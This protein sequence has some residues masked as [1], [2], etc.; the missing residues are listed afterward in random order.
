MNKILAISV[1]LGVTVMMVGSIMPTADAGMPLKYNKCDYIAQDCNVFNVGQDGSCSI[2]NF[3]K[4][5][6]MKMVINSG[7][8]PC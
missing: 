8:L 4:R 2:D 6:P 5:L 7:M 3:V 1:L